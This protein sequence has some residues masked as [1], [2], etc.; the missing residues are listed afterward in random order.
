MKNEGIG[1]G[2][3]KG[4][5]CHFLIWLKPNQWYKHNKFFS[6]TITYMFICIQSGIFPVSVV[7]HLHTLFWLCRLCDAKC[8]VVE[9]TPAVVER[10]PAGGSN[11]V[12]QQLNSK[13]CLAKLTRLQCVRTSRQDYFPVWKWIYV[14]LYGVEYMKCEA[15]VTRSQPSG[16]WSHIFLAWRWRQQALL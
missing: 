13:G 6:F 1:G 14:Y 8:C 11:T 12:F 15:D 10:T 7:G 9:R 4:H 16:M 3:R 5:V 2:L